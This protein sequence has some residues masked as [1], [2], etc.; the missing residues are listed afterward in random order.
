MFKGRE[1]RSLGVVLDRRIAITSNEQLEGI[2]VVLNVFGGAGVRRQGLNLFFF[3][4]GNC[5]VRTNGQWPIGRSNRD[6]KVLR[7]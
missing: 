6:N 7:K 3:F 5:H 1:G 4:K 2:R